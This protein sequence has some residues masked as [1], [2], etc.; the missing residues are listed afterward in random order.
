MSSADTVPECFSIACSSTTRF[1][2][3]LIQ[4]PV[5]SVGKPDP[6]LP[7]LALDLSR[8]RVLRR[9]RVSRRAVQILLDVRVDLRCTLRRQVVDELIDWL[10]ATL[11]AVVDA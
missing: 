3:R 4:D 2:D 6:Q 1:P 5:V 10:D 7:Q 8:D 11:V 9:R